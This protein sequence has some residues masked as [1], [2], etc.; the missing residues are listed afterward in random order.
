MKIVT[1]TEPIQIMNVPPI[2][3]ITLRAPRYMDLR[4]I[5]MPSVWVRLEN[6]GFEQVNEET[7]GRWVDALADIDPNFLSMVGLEDGLSLRDAVLDFFR[8]ALAARALKTTIN[9]SASSSSDST[10]APQT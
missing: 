8:E 10:G 4:D 7:L 3:A 6:G 9:S 2:S 5:G 1:L